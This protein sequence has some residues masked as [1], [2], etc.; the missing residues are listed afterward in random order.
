MSKKSIAIV[1]AGITGLSAAWALK[2]SGGHADIFERKGEPGGAIKTVQNNMWQLEYGPNTLLLKQKEVKEMIDA[3]GLKGDMITANPGAKKRYIIKNG[4]PEPLPYSVL[5]AVKTPL[6]SPGGKLRIAM[7]PF[8]FKSQNRNQSVAEFVRRRL[9][10]EILDY[11]INPFV[12]GIFANNPEDLSLQHAFPVMDSLEQEYGSLIGGAIAKYFRKKNPG[13]IPSSLVSFKNG[14]QQLPVALAKET[15]P[16]YFNHDVAK[17]GKGEGGWYIT[18]QMGVHG[19][20]KQVVVNVPVY[21]WNRDFLPVTGQQLDQL[22]AIEYPPLSIMLLGY[23][24]EDVEHPLDGFGFLVPEK[25][26]RSI[27]GALFSS[28]LFEG[29]TPEGHHLLTVFAGGGRSPDIARMESEKLLHIVQKELRELLGVTA[30]PVFKDHVFWPKSIPGYH[31][32]YDKILSVLDEIESE[33]P[34]LYL[35][36][37]FRNGI[38][39]P[40]CISNGIQLGERLAKRS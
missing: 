23:R 35:A 39:V 13:K 1:G 24:K 25:E 8:I 14:I 27:L 7:E 17:I 4:K 32:G 31:M 19:P 5:S 22:Q 16:C 10:P 20:Y 30:E 34:G 12:A 2:K 37:N 3:V 11:A 28:T 26:K 21:K 29:R 38:S 18:S 36:G 6:F 33:N 15:G 9:G 40:D